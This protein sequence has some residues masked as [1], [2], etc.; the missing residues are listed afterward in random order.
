MLQA[1]ASKETF[2]IA[3]TKLTKIHISWTTKVSKSYF[4]NVVEQKKTPIE[5]TTYLSQLNDNIH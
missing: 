2:H 4:S 5:L 3:D 1:I